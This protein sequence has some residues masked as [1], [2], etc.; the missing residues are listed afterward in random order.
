[1]Y[2][3]FFGKCMYSN[4]SL[5]SLSK[6]AWT[7]HTMLL[8]KTFFPHSTWYQVRKVLYVV[9]LVL[10]PCVGCQSFRLCQSHC[11]APSVESWSVHLLFWKFDNLWFLW[12]YNLQCWRFENQLGGRHGKCRKRGHLGGFLHLFCIHLLEC[13]IFWC[14]NYFETYLC[15]VPLCLLL[16]LMQ[17]SLESILILQSLEW[18]VATLA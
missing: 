17:M 13:Y 1:M 15:P 16:T 6:T 2:S 4:N 11:S 7:F 12:F 14:E 9:C 5:I 8:K 3:D 10:W 18:K